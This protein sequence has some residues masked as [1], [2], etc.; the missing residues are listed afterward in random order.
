[1]DSSEDYRELL[2]LSKKELHFANKRA[3]ASGKIFLDIIPNKGFRIP[4]GRIIHYPGVKKV[5]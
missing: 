2:K 5:A 4:G 1:M 3:T